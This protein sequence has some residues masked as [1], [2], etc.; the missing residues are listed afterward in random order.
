[1]FMSPKLLIITDLG[2]LKAYLLGT[3]LRGTPR[4]EPLEEIAL[5][6]AH[7][8]VVDRVSDLAGRR[9]PPGRNHNAATPLGDDHNLKLEI[10]RRL[11]REIAR[12]I[13]RLAH[14][15]P[16]TNLWLAAH[17]AIH[18]TLCDALPNGVRERIELNLSRD[19]VKA[20]TRELLAV[21][22]PLLLRVRPE[23]RTGH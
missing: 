7:Q 23:E 20:D 8:R 2:C 15:H 5:S 3:T 6:L 22:G 17:K 1:M 21:F 13:R 12:H 19:L 14:E 9:A 10:R 11:T 4:L 18:R 16:E